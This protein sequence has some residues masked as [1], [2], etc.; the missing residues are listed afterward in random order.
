[1]RLTY[2]CK[3]CVRK[4]RQE[5]SNICPICNSIMSRVTYD[6]RKISKAK[7]EMKLQDMVMNHANG[8]SNG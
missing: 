3:T 4:R 7:Q 8:R 5:N 6:E 1:M 2:F